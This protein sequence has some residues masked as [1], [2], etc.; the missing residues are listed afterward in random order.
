MTAPE[1]WPIG[2]GDAAIISTKKPNTEGLNEDSA[3]L[4]PIDDET[5]VLAVADGA[6]GCRN[7]E[8]ASRLALE[9]LLQALT[10]AHES[11]TEIRE[12]I[13]NGFE[14]ANEAVLSLGVGAATTLAVVEI[15]GNT[16]RPYHVGDS[17]VL[18][19]G[20]GGRLKLQTVP[21]S[22]VGYA[23]ES[24]LLDEKEA[25]HHDDRHFVSNLIGATDMRIEIGAPVELAERDT[26]LIGSDGLCD[27]LHTEE[28]IERSRKGTLEEALN[29]LAS[30]SVARM[31]TQS[32][33]H[34][35]KPDDFT[36]IGFRLSK[37]K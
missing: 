14:Q 11:G 12:A 9:A 1:V 17:F 19:H 8:V 25:M 32:E 10:N 6:G 13:L 23:V 24:G 5:A 7:G 20:G 29:L 16:I 36:C 28:I 15:K 33:G 4:V 21:H 26:L 2:P 31:V 22:P 3:V 34:P 37:R 35:S 18:L 30:D 27:N